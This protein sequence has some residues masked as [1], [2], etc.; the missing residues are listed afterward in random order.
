MAEAQPVFARIENESEV[1]DK[2][3]AVSKKTPKSKKTKSKQ[4]QEV[5]GA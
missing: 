3:V 4:A 5:V 2:G 1:G